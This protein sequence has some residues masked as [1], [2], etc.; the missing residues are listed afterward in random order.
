MLI[1]LVLLALAAPT[2]SALECSYPEQAGERGYRLEG[3]ALHF[4]KG[5]THTLPEASAAEAE[6]ILR[7]TYGL[8]GEGDCLV[9][10]EW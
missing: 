10:T 8:A 1:T 4:P 2:S 9:R 5:G 6:S 3:N 7:D